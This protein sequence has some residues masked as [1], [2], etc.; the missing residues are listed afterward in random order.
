VEVELSPQFAAPSCNVEVMMSS[1]GDKSLDTYRPAPEPGK[2]PAALPVCLLA[3]VVLLSLV[4]PAK[5]AGQTESAARNSGL[6]AVVQLLAIGPGGQGRNQECSATGFLVNEDGYFLTNAHV[7]QDAQRCLAASPKAKIVA[8][9]GG[10][11]A[12]V[13]TAV[14]CDVA[15]LDEDHDLAVLKTERPLAALGGVMPNE[16]ARLNP[17][18]IPV[19]TTV[20]VTGHPVFA[21][22][23]VTQTGKIIRHMLVQPPPGSA[24]P[25]GREATQ[26]LV[27]DVTLQEGHSGSP[28]YLPDGAGV[29]GIV[30]GQETADPTHSVAVSARHIIEL[31][32]RYGVK[33]YA[34]P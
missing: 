8:K 2:P 13:V 18:E 15:G 17:A 14:S 9:V 4:L 26:T 11:D 10:G 23:P 6:R 16:Y 32:D 21:W 1:I 19:G 7:I 30:V 33:W 5:A 25:A 34:K 12:E 28:V 27:I 22:Q 20:F 29:I 3:L 24:L 31:L